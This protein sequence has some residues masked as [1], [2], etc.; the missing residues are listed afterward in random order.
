MRQTLESARDERTSLRASLSMRGFREPFRQ[1]ESSPQCGAEILAS[2]AGPTTIVLDVHRSLQ[3]TPRPAPGARLGTSAEPKEPSQEGRLV[4]QHLSAWRVEDSDRE[5]VDGAA[6][7]RPSDTIH[8][9]QVRVSGT[10]LSFGD[11]FRRWRKG[12]RNSEYG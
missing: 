1:A 12:G 2:S 6:S 8:D 4:N 7:Q 5:P 10:E 3:P 9:E 11:E